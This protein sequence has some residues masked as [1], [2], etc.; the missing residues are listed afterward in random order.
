MPDITVEGVILPTVE[1][2]VQGITD[3]DLVVGPNGTA[4]YVTT[5]VVP[6]ITAFGLDPSGNVIWSDRVALG[7]QASA[8]S[9]PP[10]L[11]ILTIGGVAMAVP[12]GITGP[13]L[14]GYTLNETGLSPQPVALS[15]VGGGTSV[16]KMLAVDISGATYLYVTQDGTSGLI[17]YDLSG[18]QVATSGQS[19]HITDLVSVTIGEKTFLL[20]GSATSHA[21]LVYQIGANGA[22]HQIGAFGADDGL[23]IATPAALDVIQDGGMTYVI[24]A[25]AGSSSLSVLALGADGSLSVTDHILDTLYTRFDDA[26]V[27]ET[28]QTGD[29]RNYV[30]VAGSDDG[31]SLYALLPGGQLFHISTIADTNDMT[32]QNVSAL[33]AMVVGDTMTIYAASG[34]EPGLTELSVAL[35]P[36][37]AVIEGTQAGN[38]LSGTDGN[39]TLAGHGGN[40]SLAGGAGNDLLMDG[41]GSDTLVGGPGADIFIL[42]GDG[43][44]DV[45]SGFNPAQDEIV[46]AGWTLLYTTDALEILPT[47]TGAMITYGAETLVIHSADGGALLPSAVLAALSIDAAR[48][49]YLPTDS[50][51]PPPVDPNAPVTLV[52]TGA[53]DSLVGAGGNDLLQGL[54]GNDTLQG[55]DGKDRLE[56]GLGHDLI[57]G[58]SGNDEIL[59]HAGNDSL[60][61]QAGNDTISASSGNDTVG[62][63]AGH[64]QIGGGDGADL[65]YG[66]AGRDIIGGGNDDDVLYLGPGPDVASGGTGNDYVSGEDGDDVLAGSYHNDHV[67]GGDGNDNMGGGPG[68]DTL[69]GGA[70]NDSLG[71]GYGADTLFGGAGDDFIAGGGGA[72][73]LYGGTGDDLLNGGTGNDT[74]TGGA[75]ADTFIFSALTSGEVDIVTDFEDGIDVL[76][77]HGVKGGLKAV[78][79][80][81]NA[82]G[83]AVVSYGGHQIIIEGI[84]PDQLGGADFILV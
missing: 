45:V 24:V 38:T 63:G 43:E 34:S 61:G 77:L 1:T 3:L 74:L 69:E 32:L 50:G 6:G 71:A 26:S 12:V 23:G 82:D 42:S 16:A 2:N 47:S 10:K 59:G 15:V 57:E 21:V 36:A 31:I 25:S 30:L 46:L 48:P 78:S 4:L 81:E 19:Q 73:R 44:T 53:G 56:G 52:G 49:P 55:L 58:G 62:G 79:I 33:S 39:D 80:T 8:T 68:S 64:D 76:R 72:D 60:L 67:L 54:D 20:A 13:G 29:G 84:N 11:E 18:T 70:G 35:G 14:Q 27:I 65:L 37:G 9:T 28:V 66:G 22:P 83:D 17:A 7:A 41:A 5:Q 51:G 75:G 40:D